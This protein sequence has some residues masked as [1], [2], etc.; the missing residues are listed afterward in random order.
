M[1]LSLASRINLVI[2]ALTALTTVVAEDGAP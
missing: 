1:Q 2:G